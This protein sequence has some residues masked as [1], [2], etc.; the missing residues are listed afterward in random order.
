MVLL[1]AEY[2]MAVI[3]A[4]PLSFVALLSRGPFSIN[5]DILG[6]SQNCSYTVLSGGPQGCRGQSHPRLCLKVTWTFII[7]PRLYPSSARVLGSNVKVGQGHKFFGPTIAPQN[8]AAQPLGRGGG[9]CL[10]RAYTTVC[11]VLPFINVGVF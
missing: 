1:G 6:F 4:F 8:P 7:C 11:L 2:S 3:T 5:A 9:F 10:C